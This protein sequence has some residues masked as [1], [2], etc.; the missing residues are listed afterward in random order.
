MIYD[1]TYCSLSPTV[2]QVVIMPQ[3]TDVELQNKSESSERK[4]S[5]EERESNFQTTSC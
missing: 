4:V 3:P 5:E 1:D 2:Y